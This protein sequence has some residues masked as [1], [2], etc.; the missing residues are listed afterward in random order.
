MSTAVIKYETDSGAVELS[1]AIIKSYLVAG[2]A[3]KVTNQEVMMFLMLCKHQRLNPFLREAYLIKYGSK[4]A[5][6]VTGK[7]VFTKRANQSPKCAGWEAGVIVQNGQ[8]EYREGTFLTDD[9]KLVGG[10]AKVYLKDYKVPIASTVS[11]SEYVRTK[12]DGTPMANW[13]SM[14]ATMIRKVALVQALREAFPEDFQGL[15]SPEEMPVEMASLD[16]KP[17]QVE[18]N[19]EAVEAEIVDDSVT[20]DDVKNAFPGAKEVEPEKK[21]APEKKTDYDAT[22][23]TRPITEKQ[24]KMLYAISKGNKALMS[25][26]AEEAGFDSLKAVTREAFERVKENIESGM[27]APNI[28]EDDVPF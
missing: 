3:S 1:P 15:Y 7:D 22:G 26:A 4:P 8:L 28:D 17:I 13:K 11:M 18:D 23:D 21:Q 10:W 12:E 5:T 14:P 24:I 27:A 19:G 20:L 16:S 9:E 6:I 2:D 25:D